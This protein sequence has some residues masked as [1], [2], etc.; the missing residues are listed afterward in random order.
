MFRMAH[1]NDSVRDAGERLQIA[2]AGD[3]DQGPL[4]LGTQAMLGQ[5]R[6]AA[7]AHTRKGTPQR[8][9]RSAITWR[10]SSWKSLY[11]F[12]A[13]NAAGPS[14]PGIL[15]FCDPPWVVICLTEAAADAGIYLIPCLRRLVT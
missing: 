10:S 14:Q 1:S 13:L 6:R 15:A 4:L 8:I 12:S 3:L 5:Y 9:V 11:W 2:A 7:P